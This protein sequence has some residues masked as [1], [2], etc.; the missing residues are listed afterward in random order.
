VSPALRVG[1][2]DWGIGGLGCYRLLKEVRPTLPVTYWSD[3]G[4]TPY[5]KLGARALEER[6]SRVVHALHARG[7]SHVIVACNAASTV[8]SRI[9][10]PVPV[11]GIIEAAIASVPGDLRGTLAIV[12]GA[13]T[14]R[15]QVYR[16]AL[17]RRGRRLVCRIAQP[18]SA[19][20]EA[21]RMDSPAFH[22]DVAR[23]F[24]PLASAD[25]VLLACTHY[26]AAAEILRGQLA[27]HAQL[28]DPAEQ[29][30]SRALSAWRLGDARGADAFVTTGAVP[31]MRRAANSA[32]GLRLPHCTHVTLR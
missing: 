20:I 16:R 7:A 1:I 5:G 8:V 2:L 14:I 26:P 21:G 3:A 28:L 32:W 10:A 31:A 29:L 12:G 9:S 6:V 27:P 15:S 23:I 17:S 4:A 22:R 19:H 18:L 30:V 11:M 25:A 24:R 13:R